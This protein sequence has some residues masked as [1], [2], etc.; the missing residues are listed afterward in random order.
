M[1]GRFIS[2][3]EQPL[4]SERIAVIPRNSPTCEGHTPPPRAYQRD[5]GTAEFDKIRS[6]SV[7]KDC[8]PRL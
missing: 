8:P 7:R 2:C 5:K 6:S 4:P 1:M 3:L